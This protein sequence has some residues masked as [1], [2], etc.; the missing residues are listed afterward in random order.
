[1]DEPGVYAVP[2]TVLFN[3][4]SPVQL[5][6]W[7]FDPTNAVRV[8]VV[9]S[10]KKRVYGREGGVWKIVDGSPFAEFVSD[11]M[12]EVLFRISSWDSMRYAVTDEAALLK[13]GRFS[14]VAHEMEIQLSGQA[15]LQTMRLK[16]GGTIAG[17]RYVLARFDEDQTGLRLEMPGELYVQ[18]IRF[19]G[20]P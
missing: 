10:G 19:L 12:E 13:V 3:L 18:L 9:N 8:T 20:L 4:D 14:E 16:F 6:S 2:R 7:R 17:N 11:A 1:M 15:G 5:R